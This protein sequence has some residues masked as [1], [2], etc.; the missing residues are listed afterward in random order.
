M[1]K[2]TFNIERIKHYKL[3]RKKKSQNIFYF[4]IFFDVLLKQF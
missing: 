2:K 4:I 3:F 1:K